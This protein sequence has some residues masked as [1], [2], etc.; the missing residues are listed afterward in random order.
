MTTDSKAEA[1]K[2]RDPKAVRK[3]QHAQMAILT[4]D[5]KAKDPTAKEQ[6]RT[7]CQT[8]Q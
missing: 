1:S 6:K 8:F 2:P 5:A 4:K 7:T 3:K